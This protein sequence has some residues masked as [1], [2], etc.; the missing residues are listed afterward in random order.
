MDW[1]RTSGGLLYR[2][3]NESLGLIKGVEFREK[4]NICYFLKKISDLWV[5]HDKK[6]LNFTCIYRWNDNNPWVLTSQRI[7]ILDITNSTQGHDG[8]PLL[9][10]CGRVHTVWSVRPL[11]LP[12]HV[13]SISATQKH[14]T[15]PPYTDSVMKYIPHKK[16]RALC[17]D[18]SLIFQ[19]R[20]SLDCILCIVFPI[21]LSSS[22]LH[23][24][25]SLWPDIGREVKITIP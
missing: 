20:W 17:T 11:H 13:S 14:D 2:H 21:L 1:I 10:I 25:Y 3:G 15:P 18:A 4:L 7:T 19:S 12:V 23:I 22:T 24:K 8:P 9:F 16:S 5:S 6:P